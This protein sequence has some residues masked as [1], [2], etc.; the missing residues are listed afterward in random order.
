ML[1]LYEIE[2]NYLAALDLF[3]D[4]DQEIPPE[5]VAD[6][7]EAIEGEFEIK[8][9]R[10]AAFAKQMEAE[11]EAIKEAADRMEKRRRSLEARARWLKDYVKIGLEAMGRKKLDCPW[12][13]LSVA[14]NPPAVVIF[15]E[16]A[17][18]AE[19]MRVPEPP[20]PAPDKTAI[21][22]ALAAGREVPG[23]RLVNGTRLAIR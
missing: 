17:I 14:N 7:L 23:A 22:A 18:P 19:F 16:N 20:P 3:T 9:V 5:V 12:F 10:V 4:P 13:V 8:A 11:A 15:D 2:Q 6:T 21:K 1:K